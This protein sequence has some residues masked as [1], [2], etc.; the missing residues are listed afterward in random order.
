MT[1]EDMV[2]LER[3]IEHAKR[4]IELGN[5]VDR[6]V[7]NRDF[8]K[9]ILDEYLRE[10][11]IRLVHLLSDPSMNSP[12]SRQAITV[13]MEAISSFRRFLENKTQLAEISRKSLAYDEQA[14]EDMLIEGDD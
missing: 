14:R 8:K 11:P 6:L 5:N 7:N 4:A 13:Q 10:E 2:M 3:S 9:L 12:E 1:N